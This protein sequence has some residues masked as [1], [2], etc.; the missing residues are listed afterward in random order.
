MRT[1]SSSVK[2]R[3]VSFQTRERNGLRFV[4][5]FAARSVASDVATGV[6]TLVVARAKVRN[7]KLKFDFTR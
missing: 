6:A 5:G 3:L 2:R 7:Q 1:S 4:F